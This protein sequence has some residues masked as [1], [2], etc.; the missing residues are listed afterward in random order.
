MIFLPKII[1]EFFCGG[2]ILMNDR[3]QINQKNYQNNLCLLLNIF[4]QKNI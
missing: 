2:D 3:L 1:H 4:F